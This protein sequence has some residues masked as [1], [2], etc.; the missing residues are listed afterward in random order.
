MLHF[1]RRHSQSRVIQVIFFLIIAVFVLWGVEAVVS[2]GSPLTTIATVDGQPIEQ[3]S[4]QRAEMNLAQAY[5]DAYKGQFT[6]EMQKAMNL[7]QRAL[8]GLIDRA[9]LAGQAE[10]LGYQ[11]DDQEL[12]DSIVDNPAFQLGGRFNKDQYL[13]VLRSAGLTPGDFESAKREDLA[14]GRVQ[15]LIGD[16]V[17]VSDDDVRDDIVSRE[18]KRTLAFVKIPAADLTAQVQVTDAELEKF[19]EDNKARYAEPEKVKVELLGYPVDRFQDGVEVT[20]ERITEHYETNLEARYTQPH[21]VRARHIL[22]RVPRDA[23]EATKAKAR[24]RIDEAKG[25]IDA[26]GDFAALAKAYSEDPGSKEKGGDLGF[27]P[28]GRM[29]GAFDEAAFA[30]KP[31][32]VSDVVESPFGFNV[33]KVEEVRE[34]RKKPLEEV[35]EEVVVTLRNESATEKARAAADEDATALG[36]GATLDQI[37]EKRGLTV[38]RPEPLARNAAFPSLGRSLPLTNALWELKPGGLTAPVDVNGT[39][40]IGKLI[41]NVASVTPPFAEVKDRVDAAYRLQKATDAAKAEAEKVLAAARSDGLEAAGTA[42]SRKVEV[43][44]AFARTGPFIP[45][46]GTNPAVKDAA[47]ALAQDRKLGDKVFV[48]GSD[49]F[50]VELREVVLPSDADVQ[51]KMIEAKKQLLDKRREDAFARYLGELKKTAQIEVNAERLEAIPGA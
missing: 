23:D 30:L 37:A 11:I 20:E 6:P 34:E 46:M 22:V 49:A 10:K 33:I 32:E 28:R 44:S 26:G 27:F 15:N 48:I 7:R 8:D 40:V 14:V 9:I 19:Y 16:N 42:S 50:V 29:V 51:A 35:R 17:T 18:E 2:G 3:I 45:G 31:G 12:R 47:F 25:K 36:N 5:R 43:S 24:A 41:E 38:D 4:I 13:R 39:I 21:E 1:L